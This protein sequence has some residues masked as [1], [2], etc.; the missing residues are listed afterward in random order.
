MLTQWPPAAP[1]DKTL[2][3]RP[4]GQQWFSYAARFRQSHCKC[5]TKRGLQQPNLHKCPLRG[6]DPSR[7]ATWTLCGGW[8]ARPLRC[9]INNTGQLTWVVACS[10]R[11]CNYA[12]PAWSRPVALT[13]Q[14]VAVAVVVLLCSHHLRTSDHVNESLTNWTP[15]RPSGGAVACPRR[16]CDATVLCVIGQHAGTRLPRCA[17]ALVASTNTV[18]QATVAGLLMRTLVLLRG[19]VLTPQRF[20]PG[21]NRS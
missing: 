15:N 10:S 16:Y 12:T 21:L 6:V 8:T 17:D 3:L 2:V 11:I 19:A 20:G 18:R 14:L 5:H 9:V 13:R 7:A 1:H 4:R